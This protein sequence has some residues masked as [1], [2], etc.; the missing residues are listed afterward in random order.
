MSDIL[1]NNNIE[2]Q[3]LR[4]DNNIN[5]N[6]ECNKIL[7]LSSFTKHKDRHG[8]MSLICNK[9]RVCGYYKGVLI[10]TYS[11]IIIPTILYFIFR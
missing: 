8:N 11:I 3:N 7:F 2:I 1:E 5:S 9:E 10:F 6:P 4:K